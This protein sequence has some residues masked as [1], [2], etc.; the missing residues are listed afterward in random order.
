MKL[1]QVKKKKPTVK[2]ST[3]TGF[4]LWEGLSQHDN[5]PIAA[6]ATMTSN[7]VKTGNMIQTWIIRTD[8]EP[9]EAVKNSQDG[10]VCGACP[11]KSGAGCY[12]RTEQAPLAVYRA[13]HK[14]NYKR[15]SIAEIPLI[16]IN[17]TVR[18]G[19]YGDPAFV[20]T[21]IWKALVSNAI[22]FTG[23]THQH[24]QPWFDPNLTKYCMVSADTIAESEKLN[25]MGIRTFTAIS[26]KESVPDNQLICPNFTHGV[27]CNDCKL[28]DGGKNGKSII[29]PIHGVKQKIVKFIANR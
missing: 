18:I 29:A 13:Y 4:I 12:V 20:P 25:A 1:S 5:K 17:R 27:I 10:S 26:D 15:V 19:A 23:Y 24:K 21:H 28:C 16:A 9:H 6:I 3:Q 2:K 11:F 22:G 14:G 7:N 8:I